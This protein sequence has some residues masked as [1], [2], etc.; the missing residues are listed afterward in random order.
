MSTV[1]E[2]VPEAKKVTAGL[3]DVRNIIGALLGI[4]GIVL[5]IMGIT[6]YT[7]AEKAK[8]DNVN[9]NLWTGLGL[10]IVAAL[11]IVW[12]L[13]RPIVVAVEDTPASP[14]DD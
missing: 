2:A 1:P 9:M 6:N 8:S 7:A 14:T 11:M 3:F 5:L 13:A 12:A 4:Y 10:L